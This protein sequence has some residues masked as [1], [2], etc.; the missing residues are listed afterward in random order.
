MRTTITITF[1]DDKS[2]DKDTTS[3]LL[4]GQF[5]SVDEQGS[6]SLTVNEQRKPKI[7]FTLTS[8][9]NNEDRLCVNEFPSAWNSIRL[10]DEENCHED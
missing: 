10:E 9:F 1:Y 2:E 5:P 7:F 3:N 6:F 8:N 4:E